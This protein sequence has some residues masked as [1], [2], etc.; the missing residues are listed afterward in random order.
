[1][2]KERVPN[3]HFLL[4]IIDSNSNLTPFKRRTPKIRMFRIDLSKI[5]L[6]FLDNSK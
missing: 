3:V 4:K 2:I 1:M 6:I 5:G